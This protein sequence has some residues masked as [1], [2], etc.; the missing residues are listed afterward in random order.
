M[1]KG[2]LPS[3]RAVA[4]LYSATGAGLSIADSKVIAQGQCGVPH[5]T[6][7]GDGPPPSVWF[8]FHLITTR[9]LRYASSPA[10]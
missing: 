3:L 2:R 9:G 4:S 6:A 8:L 1:R 7:W 5:V 10:L